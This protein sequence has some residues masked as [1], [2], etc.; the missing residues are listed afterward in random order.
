MK[1]KNVYCLTC[2]TSE[3]MPLVDYC[4]PVLCLFMSCFVV[5]CYA[6]F[7]SRK[8]SVITLKLLRTTILASIVLTL[9]LVLNYF[10][11]HSTV[12]FSITILWHGFYVCFILLSHLY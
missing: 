3:I 2:L 6:W 12:I 11:L 10:V 8:E 7:C 4:R 1:A 5:R 9:R